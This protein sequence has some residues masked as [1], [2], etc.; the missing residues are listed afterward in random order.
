MNTIMQSTLDTQKINAVKQ[1]AFCNKVEAFFATF[2]LEFSPS[3]DVY[4]A[5]YSNTV[6]I[7]VN[8]RDDLVTALTLAPLWS[9]KPTTRHII[10]SATVTVGEVPLEINIYASGGALP[11]T[12]TLIT[13][14]VIVPARE[15][16][17][18]TRERLQ[19][20]F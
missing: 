12:C 1:L 5:E 9:K 17:T 10:Y 13:E 14:E 15:A 7:Y 16:Y 3:A 18:E 11:P 8:N 20:N 6:S 2:T 19:C 4:L